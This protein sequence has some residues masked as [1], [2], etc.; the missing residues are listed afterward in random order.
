MQIFRPSQTTY[1]TTWQVGFMERALQGKQIH[2]AQ[3]LWTTT[4]QNIGALIKELANYLSPFLIN[5]YRR[6]GLLTKTEQKKFPLQ[7]HAHDGDETLSAN[8]VDTS[9][10]EAQLALRSG[11]TDGPRDRR[12]E[13]PQKRRKLQ[14]VAVSK[15]RDC[16]PV[17]TKLKTPNAWPRMKVKARP[18]ILEDVSSTESSVVALQ[19]RLTSA[20]APSEKPLEVLTVLTVSLDTEKDLVALEKI[21]KRVV[22]GVA[23]EATAQH[24]VVS[25][26]T[27]TRTVILETGEDPL[28]EEIQSERVNAADVL[29][30]Q[31]VPLLRYLDTKLEM[32]VGPTHVGSYVRLVRNMTRVKVA[33]AHAVEKEKQHR[34]T[35]AKYEVLRKRLAKEVELRKTSEKACESIRVR[36]ATV[37]LRDRLEASRVAFN[38]KSRKVDELTVDLEKKDQAHATKMVVKLSDMEVKLLEAEEKNRQLAERTN[39]ALTQKFE[40]SDEELEIEQTIVLR[41]L[42][43]DWK[44][45]SA[46]TADSAC[47]VPVRSL[48]QSE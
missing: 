14:K 18:L 4:R 43:L 22:E 25:P 39:D 8:E 11:R 47:G 38:E 34:E 2:W 36:R 10:E 19:G 35:E 46:A 42:G 26:R 24:Q 29:C 33:A 15:V 31:V 13:R 37:D 30:G 7:T 45:D 9:Q 6:M 5:F 3:I 48:H 40:Q 27:S 44:S 16:Q 23:A 21:V 28:E 20:E 32:Y 12:E 17:L 1:M 41:R